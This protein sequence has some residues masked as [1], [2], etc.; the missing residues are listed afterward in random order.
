MLYYIL[1]LFLLENTNQPG[2]RGLEWPPFSPQGLREG[3]IK[4]EEVADTLLDRVSLNTFFA[5][6]RSFHRTFVT[7]S[8]QL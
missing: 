6:S 7:P 1:Q 3:V 4:P 8:R 5:T 2:N